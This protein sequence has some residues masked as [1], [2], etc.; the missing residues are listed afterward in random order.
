MLKYTNMPYI[1]NWP[2]LRPPKKACEPHLT[3]TAHRH[4]FLLHFLRLTQHDPSSSTLKPSPA[5]LNFN[6]RKK[7]S[8]TLSV[9][10]T[11]V[12]PW[13]FPDLHLLLNPD[14]IR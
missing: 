1:M 10:L 3:D 4:W 2:V 5:V 9:S 7:A 12:C 13:A 14:E 11:I 6:N 8:W